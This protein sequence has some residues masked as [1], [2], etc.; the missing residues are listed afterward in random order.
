MLEIEL[1]ED[2]KMF[3]KSKASKKIDNMIKNQ[4]EL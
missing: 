1:A 4:G 3:D 2:R